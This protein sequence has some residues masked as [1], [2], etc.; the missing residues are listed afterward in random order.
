MADKTIVIFH[1]VERGHGHRDVDPSFARHADEIAPPAL[2]RMLAI[3]SQAGVRASYT[4]LGVIF[5]E[6][7]PEVRKADHAVGFHS[8]DHNVEQTVANSRYQ[9]QQC[10]A[11]GDRARGYRPP[12]SKIT[13]ELDRVLADAGFEWL[14]SS[15]RS[16]G[17]DVPVRRDRLVCIPIVAD[18]FDLYRGRVDF[19][20]WEERVL[21]AVEEREFAAVGL[22]D[23][24]AEF[25]LDHYRGFLERIATKGTL[26]TFD[27]VADTL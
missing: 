24:Y 15:A 12:Q 8:F 27:E 20:E 5:D 26:K 13:P 19:G 22:H 18:D 4:V 16:L 11:T 1:D 17:T 2:T 7:V 14:A 3:E 6:V 9:V 23:C 21:A 10:L 25:W